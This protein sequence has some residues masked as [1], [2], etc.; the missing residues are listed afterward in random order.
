MR[1]CYFHTRDGE[2]LKLD[3][4]GTDLPDDQSA[5]HAAEPWRPH[6]LFGPVQNADGADIYAAK[7]RLDG[8]PAGFRNG[9]MLRK[10][11]NG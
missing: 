8:T 5:R 4:E 7:L 2:K 10:L 3:E 11:G 6:I 9:S 1:S